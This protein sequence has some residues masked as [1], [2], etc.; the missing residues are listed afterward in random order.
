MI[1]GFTTS[2]WAWRCESCSFIDITTPDRLMRDDW[3][4]SR[5]PAGWSAVI[6]F[7]ELD[8]TYGNDVQTLLCPA[9][10]VRGTK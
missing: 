7:G 3:D 10:T 2:G 1:T 9:C 4:R 5:P 8:H 6:I